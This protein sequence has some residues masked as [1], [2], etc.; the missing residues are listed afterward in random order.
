MNEQDWAYRF[1]HEV[2]DLLSK[3]GHVDFEPSPD[4]YRELL[5]LARTLIV[6]DF[7]HE[8]REEHRLR[9]R[10]LERLDSPAVQ[11]SRKESV[12]K[13]TPPLSVRR[14]L[15]ASITVALAILLAVTFLFPG[16][17]VAAAQSIAN[18]VKLIVLG[19]YTTAQQ[20]ESI[21]TGEPL[22]DDTWNI[23]LFPGVGVGGNGPPGTYPTV[24]S[25][26]DLEEAQELTLFHIREPAYLPEGYILKEIKLAPVWTGL[27]DLLFP[28]NPN[29]F[30][31]Y[32][33]PDQDIVIV[34]QPVGPQ[35]IG[36]SGVVAG[37]F[38]GF[39]TNGTLVEVEMN[40][41]IAAW[42]DDRLLIWEQDGVSYMVGGIGLNLE[43]AI[44]IAT[45]L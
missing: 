37:N 11:R 19:T 14:R 45:S 34:Q 5:D 40:G 3:S 25:V 38:I 21:I 1:S 13:P 4:D 8:S 29:V 12:F 28:I 10:L 32:V 26:K 27:G 6:T 35:P 16:G 23:V 36:E 39:A 41:H 42:A 9:W 43:E 44:R 2:D 17:P 20:I 22:P 18:G 31:F 30:F 15:L 24:S 7:S 33:G